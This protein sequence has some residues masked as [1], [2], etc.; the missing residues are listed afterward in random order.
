MAKV[1][2]RLDSDKMALD[3]LEWLA[4][5]MR[6]EPERCRITFETMAKFDEKGRVKR[7]DPAAHVAQP[8][9]R[10]KWFG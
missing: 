2:N 5:K 10:P 4:R 6:H 9:D 1:L 7:I 3:R 8:P